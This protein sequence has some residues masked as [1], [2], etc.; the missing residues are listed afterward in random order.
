MKQSIIRRLEQIHCQNW[1]PV[2]IYYLYRMPDGSEVRK[3]FGSVAELRRWERKTG[4][5]HIN[6]VV[7]KG[8][9]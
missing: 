9:E 1:G 4:A 6:V 2:K 7:E 8:E 5:E 3:R